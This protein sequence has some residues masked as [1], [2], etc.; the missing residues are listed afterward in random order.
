[1]KIFP[2][3][4]IWR[5]GPPGND[6]QRF[7]GELASWVGPYEWN[8]EEEGTLIGSWRW[9]WLHSVH[10]PLVFDDAEMYEDLWSSKEDRIKKVAEWQN[11]KLKIL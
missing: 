4:T 6:L 2:D 7:V 8:V 5:F 10:Q 1:M 11:L 3:H 9:R